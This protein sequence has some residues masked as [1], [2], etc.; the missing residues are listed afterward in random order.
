MQDSVVL[1]HVSQSVTTATEYSQ[2]RRP[3]LDQDDVK[4]LGRQVEKAMACGRN[5]H[6]LSIADVRESHCTPRI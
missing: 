5:V 6:D 3:A 4:D 1:D 2:G